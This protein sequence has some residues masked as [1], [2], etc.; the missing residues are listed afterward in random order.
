MHGGKPVRLLHDAVFVAEHEL[1]RGDGYERFRVERAHSEEPEGEDGG[2]V[3]VLPLRRER[4]QNATAFRRRMPS[5]S[6][7]YVTRGDCADTVR[8]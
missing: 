5:R 4:L 2:F 8:E 1:L 6:L 3:D 7:N